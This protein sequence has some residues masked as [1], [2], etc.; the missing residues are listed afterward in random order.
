MI[1][2]ETSQTGG[3]EGGGKGSAEECREGE[4]VE[5]TLLALIAKY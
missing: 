3:R 5:E 1:K 2:D 4:R